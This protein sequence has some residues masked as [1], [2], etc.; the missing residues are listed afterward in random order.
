MDLKTG[1]TV[2]QLQHGSPPPRDPLRGHE[3]CEVA[4]IGGGITGALIAYEM[5]KAGLDCLL[6]D[7]REPGDGSTSASTA[8]LSY[9][10]DTPLFALAQQIGE[11]DAVACYR[12]CHH[13][14]DEIEVIVQEIAADCHFTRR[15]SAYLAE[16]DDAVADLEQELAA[17]RKAGLRIDLFD[18]SE[19]EN[20]FS[21]TRPA[22]LFHADAAEVDVVALEAAVLNRA[23]QMGLRAFG[24]TRMASAELGPDGATILTESGHRIATRKLVFA[25]GYESEKY[26]GRKVGKLKSTF[27][28]A[29]EPLADFPG[30]HDRCHIWTSARPYLYLRTT[31]DGRAIIGGED[32]DF[33]DEKRRDALLPAKAAR[34]EAAFREMFPGITG[35]IACAWTGTFGET[36]DSLAYIGQPHPGSPAYFALGYGG[37]GITYGAIAAKIIRDACMGREHPAARLFRFDR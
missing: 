21:F 6:I 1:T 28:I 25:T 7:K 34:L 32:V 12:A 17:R 20:L 2:W 30:W 14:I 16:T 10:L 9:E 4:I 35:R 22:A 11:A 37:N 15:S 29:T 31:A 27:A 3:S 36:K 19:I 26:L 24:K 13:A 33:E 23:V 18:R 8:L 5:C